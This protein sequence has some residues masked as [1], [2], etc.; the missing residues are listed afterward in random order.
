VI[1]ELRGKT[2]RLVQA[3][4]AIPGHTGTK[5]KLRTALGGA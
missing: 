5:A 4:A 3:D 2:V 1:R